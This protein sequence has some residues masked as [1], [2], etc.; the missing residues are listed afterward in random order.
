MIRFEPSG[1]KSLVIVPQRK[2]LPRGTLA[3]VLEQAG[4]TLEE[5][6]DL[7]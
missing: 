6:I 2:E 7:L 1:R 5:F 3:A 4:L